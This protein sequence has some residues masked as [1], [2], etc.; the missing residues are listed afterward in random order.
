VDAVL[1][2][3]PELG[4]GHPGAV[5]LP[6]VTDLAWRQPHYGQAVQVE[7]LGQALGVELIGLAE[8]T[9]HGC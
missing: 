2:G 6:L 1:E 9:R 7:E 8:G 5:E 4:E 3:G